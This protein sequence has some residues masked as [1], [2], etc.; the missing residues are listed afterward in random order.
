LQ[1]GGS[2][3]KLQRVGK[4]IIFAVRR[5][6]KNGIPELA[7][8]VAGTNNGIYGRLHRQVAEV[9]QPKALSWS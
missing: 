7:P 3:S 9:E 4:S 8:A 1:P 6:K 2:G 5:A